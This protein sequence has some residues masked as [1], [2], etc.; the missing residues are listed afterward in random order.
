MVEQKIQPLFPTN[1]YLTECLYEISRIKLRSCSTPGKHKAENSCIEMSKMS[2][3]TLSVLAYSPGWHSS[4][5]GGKYS[6]RKFPLGGKE[7]TGSCS[8]HSS[9]SEGSQRAG[10]CVSSL[11]TLTELAQFGCLEA[12]ENKEKEAAFCSWHGFVQSKAAQLEASPS[13]RRERSKLFN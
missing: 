12:T 9:F 11:G 13:R 3:F 10:F 1:T 2:N 6:G 4:A 7:N 5:L 8:K